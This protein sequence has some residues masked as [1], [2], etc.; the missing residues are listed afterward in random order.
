[1]AQLL[2]RHIFENE[3]RE[4][5]LMNNKERMLIRMKAA[6]MILG[7]KIWERVKYTNSSELNFSEKTN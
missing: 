6:E 7:E 3:I 1:M 2:I 4:M 5:H